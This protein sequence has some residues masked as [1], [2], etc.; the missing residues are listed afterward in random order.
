MHAFCL[1]PLSYLNPRVCFFFK[2]IVYI[3]NTGSDFFIMSFLLHCLSEQ[4]KLIPQ[5]RY[6]TRV[7]LIKIF[8]LFLVCCS[9]LAFFITIIFSE[10]HPQVTFLLRR[11]HWHAFQVFSLRKMVFF[12]LHGFCDILFQLWGHGAA[13]HLCLA[14]RLVSAPPGFPPSLPS[15]APA[16]G[17]WQLSPCFG[18]ENSPGLGS[19]VGTWGPDAQRAPLT[20]RWLQLPPLRSQRW[21]PPTITVTFLLCVHHYSCMFGEI[22]CWN[23]NQDFGFLKCFIKSHVSTGHLS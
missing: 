13:P 2:E 22:V 5:L 1:T 9:L 16:G 18:T 8:I 17:S 21:A 23:S 19:V 3:V 20:Q 10:A 12:H 6:W 4:L 15:S 14:F 7:G 11:V